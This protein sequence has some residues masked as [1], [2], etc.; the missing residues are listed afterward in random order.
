MKKKIY[1]NVSF[2]FLWRSF[3]K[4]TEVIIKI[5]DVLCTNDTFCQSCEGKTF[6]EIVCLTTSTI[7]FKVAKKL[8]RRCSTGF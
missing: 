5:L 6:P 1:F 8:H 4:S 2:L 3:G 7:E